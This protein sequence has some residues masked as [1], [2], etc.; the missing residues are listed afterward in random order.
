MSKSSRRIKEF[1][2]KLCRLKRFIKLVTFWKTPIIWN[3]LWEIFRSM[4]GGFNLPKVWPFQSLKFQDPWVAQFEDHKVAFLRVS[5][6]QNSKPFKNP[7]SVNI[8]WLDHQLLHQT[9]SSEWRVKRSTNYKNK[10]FRNFT[11][12]GYRFEVVSVLSN[13][14]WFLIIFLFNQRMYQSSL[15]TI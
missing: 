11:K 5:I 12:T 14:S 9:K 3:G 7:V 15:K 10:V 4:P 6:A 2:Q 8:E 1:A 13:F